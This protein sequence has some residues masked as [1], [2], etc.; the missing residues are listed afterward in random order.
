MTAYAE[1]GWL[2]DRDEERAKLRALHTA[3]AEQDARETSGFLLDRFHAGEYTVDAVEYF[4]PVTKD[5]IYYRFVVH[6]ATPWLIDVG[7]EPLNEASWAQSH[8]EAA[9]RGERQFQIAGTRG[10][11]HAEYT[12]FSGTPDYDQVKARVLAIIVGQPAARP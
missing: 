12:S 2:H 11:E 3:A 8:A 1:A 9:A 4:A 10:S 6:V 7:S 5:G